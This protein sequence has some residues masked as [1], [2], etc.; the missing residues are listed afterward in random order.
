MKKQPDQNTGSP[1]PWAEATPT[2]SEAASAESR[3]VVTASR[4]MIRLLAYRIANQWVEGTQGSGDY[5]DLSPIE[6]FAPALFLKVR[7]AGLRAPEAQAVVQMAKA[8]LHSMGQRLNWDPLFQP[9][10]GKLSTKFRWILEAGDARFR[11]LTDADPSGRG[12]LA[13]YP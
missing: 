7:E 1:E 5:R 10:R 6:A 13:E 4:D 12:R 8:S 3:A 11:I 2:E 9:F